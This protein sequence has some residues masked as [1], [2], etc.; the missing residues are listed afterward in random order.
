[1]STSSVRITLLLAVASVSL[2]GCLNLKP[3]PSAARYFVLATVP[4]R[5]ANSETNIS[6]RPPI[7]GI[8]PVKLP[9]YL[10]KNTLAVRKNPN[11]IE[12]LEDARWAEALNQGFLRALASNLAARALPDQIRLSAWH[13]EEV[14]LEAHI[15]IEQFDVDV[16]GRGRLIAWWRILSPSSE[17][18]VKAGQ[19]QT[20]ANGP[21]PTDDPGGAVATLS[22]MVADLSAELTRVIRDIP[23]VKAK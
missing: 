4:A 21:R 14:T 20:S 23:A 2:C 12:Y 5:N 18:T 16:E 13:S 15:S 17:Q 3:V 11:E 19:F 7:I 22:Q 1:M 8:A 6:E 10:L 9:T